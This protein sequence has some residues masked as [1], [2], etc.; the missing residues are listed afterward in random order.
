ML[1]NAKTCYRQSNP[2]T[3]F[4]APA[5]P[6][7]RHYM[8]NGK[9]CYPTCYASQKRVTLAKHAISRKQCYLPHDNL[10]SNAI[11]C[12]PVP[13]TYYP[14]SKD[15]QENI[16][17]VSPSVENVPNVTT[18]CYLIVPKSVIQCRKNHTFAT[19]NCFF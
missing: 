3:C 1:F 16:F 10:L 12:F 17:N 15:D 2:Y 13:K 18:M 14:M 19:L 5:S 6:Q 9:T 7:P 11:T 8:E 4:G